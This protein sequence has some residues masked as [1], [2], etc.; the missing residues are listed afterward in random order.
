MNKYITCFSLE[1]AAALDTGSD[2]NCNSESDT[3]SD[4]SPEDDE[5][6]DEALLD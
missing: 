6:E 1:G 4:N 2:V 3:D 5:D